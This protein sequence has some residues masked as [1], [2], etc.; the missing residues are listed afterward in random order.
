MPDVW[1]QRETSEG[2][3]A[4][5]ND[6][7]SKMSIDLG[8]VPLETPGR[9]PQIGEQFGLSNEE[10]RKVVE[11]FSNGTG[12]DP[13][14]FSEVLNGLFHRTDMTLAEKVFVVFTLGCYQGRLKARDGIEVVVRDRSQQEAN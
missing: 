6:G 4:M 14:L 13:M 1:V 10:A 8:L 5:T 3:E 7:K 12:D 9:T 2:E 11:R